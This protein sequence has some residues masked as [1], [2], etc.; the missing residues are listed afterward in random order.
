MRIFSVVTIEVSDS[1]LFM[2]SWQPISNEILNLSNIHE[3]NI[4]D[5]TVLLSLDNYIGRNAFVAHCFWISFMIFAGSIN[6]IS[7]LRGRQTVITFD[8]SRVD[9]LALQFPLSQPVVKWNVSS[10]S[11]KLVVQTMNTLG[12]RTMLAKQPCSLFFI[13]WVNCCT[14]QTFSSWPVVTFWFFLFLLLALRL[15]FGLS[16]DAIEATPSRRVI[17]L[18][19]NTALSWLKRLYYKSL[20]LMPVCEIYF[21]GLREETFRMAPSVK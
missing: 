4:V 18:G 19:V 9:S 20:A 17:T 6:L 14:I 8:F 3:L 13:L 16:S 10:I 1:L 12:I 21:L 7:H 5:M 15:F 11:N 2:V